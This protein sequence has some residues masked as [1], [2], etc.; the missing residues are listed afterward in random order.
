MYA[1]QVTDSMERAIT[2][3]IRRRGIQQKY[4]EEHGI[5]PTTIQ[6]EVREILEI[7]TGRNVEERTKRGKKMS[8]REREELI[9]KHTLSENESL[10]MLE[11]LAASILRDE[12]R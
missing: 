7:S 12:N 1:D 5:I 3:T 2:E 9:A 4:N 11:R 6:K 10:E 8:Q